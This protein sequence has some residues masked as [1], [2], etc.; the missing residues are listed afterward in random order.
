MLTDS[1]VSR[2]GSA[3]VEISG[4]ILKITYSRIRVL[5]ESKADGYSNYLLCPIKCCR[6]IRVLEAL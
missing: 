2:V 5:T 4:D 3:L 6:S 1:I